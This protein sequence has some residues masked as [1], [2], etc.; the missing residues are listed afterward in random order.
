MAYC[1]QEDLLKLIPEVELAEL[2]AES[3]DTPDSAIVSDCIGQADAE[4]NSYLAVRYRFPLAAT[5]DRVKSLSIDIAIYHI[6]SRRD[7]IPE[8]RRQKYKDAVAFLKAVALGRA[9]IIGADGAEI[10][11]EA[12]EVVEITSQTRV[13][14]RDKLRNL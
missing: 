2:T 10:S 8:S 1:S 14:D 12:A 9:E 5:P 13:F 6:Y 4:I 3:G 11:G 7:R